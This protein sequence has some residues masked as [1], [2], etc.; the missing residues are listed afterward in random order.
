MFLGVFMRMAIGV[1]SFKTGDLCRLCVDCHFPKR[2]GKFPKSDL[3]SFLGMF[4]GKWQDVP[5][6]LA[7]EV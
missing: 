4:L 6:D 5:D 7:K 2:K 1:E 3:I